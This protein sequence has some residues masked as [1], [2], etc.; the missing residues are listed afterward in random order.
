MKTFLTTIFSLLGFACLSQNYIVSVNPS[1]AFIGQTLDV[2]ITGSNTQF[3]QSSTTAFAYFSQSSST[4]TYANFITWISN[5][6]IIANFSIPA[7]TNP[8]YYSIGVTDPF[9]TVLA[10]NAFN[11]VD[12]SPVISTINPNQGSPGQTLDVTITGSNT[13][14]SQ[15]NNTATLTF[16]QGSGT[17]FSIPANSAIP[18]TDNS[19]V[20][21]FSI[22]VNSPL[23]TYNLDVNNLIDGNLSA[24]YAFT[25]QGISST[26]VISGVN[27]NQGN[28][29]QTLDVTITGANTHFMQGQINAVSFGFLQGSGTTVNSY[30]PI[31]DS[32]LSANVTIPSNTA[33]GFYSVLVENSIDGL[34]YSNNS[35]YVNGS[36]P[37]VTSISPNSGYAG[38][39]LD[40]VITGINTHFLQSS[41][42]VVSMSFSP[43]GGSAVNSYNV[44]NDETI[45]A[46]IT[47]PPNT[48][49]DY[50][51]LMVSN[52]IDGA[53]Y[54]TNFYVNGAPSSGFTVTA[55]P[56]DAS[57]SN[58]CDGAVALT[59]Y[60]DGGNATFLL[61]DYYG[62][63][64]PLSGNLGSN[65]CPGL[66]SVNAQDASGNSTSLT[67]LIGYPD[68][69]YYSSLDSINGFPIIS[70]GVDTSCSFS[71]A[72]ID[73]VS[74]LSY[75]ILDQNPSSAY[76]VELVWNI[77][78]GGSPITYSNVYFIG[79]S[80]YYT[81][82]LQLFCDST[83]AL[84]FFKAFD[85]SYIDI[86]NVGTGNN[87]SGIAYK[88][89]PNPFNELI[90]VSVL[91]SDAHFLITNELG[92]TVKDGSLIKGNSLI[93][94]R[95]LDLGL[96]FLHI[97]TP[98]GI[99]K[100][101][102]IKQ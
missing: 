7:T 28:P 19:V 96:Y 66:Y 10:A 20:A 22:P 50:Y 8:G 78:T 90:T 48:L 76:S 12:S 25:I 69:I 35:F 80:G 37:V 63:S 54:L 85:Y 11:V 23:G 34:L 30:Y 51:T 83:R 84:E 71:Y 55:S 75:T 5:S 21:N 14:F 70:N 27:P 47:I 13:H 40:V 81:F 67:F 94:L 60:N 52:S 64:I 49:T 31:N 79:Q 42:T 62:N 74:I 65:L 88:I 15:G 9:E 17:V 92:Q 41:S 33:P 100:V 53:L 102:L 97:Q 38:Q 98:S 1:S 57:G 46:N 39:T 45:F 101:K 89:F 91:D 6:Q 58:S 59:S 32:T 29:G 87:L 43:G 93:D 44:L 72:S 36:S 26:A 18:L 99:S 4:V 56:V 3:T 16:N 82:E 73:S 86:F 95:K 77:Y 24:L 61:F 68:I 2:T